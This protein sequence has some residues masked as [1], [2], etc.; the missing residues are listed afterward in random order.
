MRTR[1]RLELA[2]FLIER[3]A[4]EVRAKGVFQRAS[5]MQ[6]GC[7]TYHSHE[8]QFVFTENVLIRPNEGVTSCSLDVWPDGAGKV[9]SMVWKPERPWLP[10]EIVS[11]KPGPWIERLGFGAHS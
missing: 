7:L 10:P 3:V 8:L 1:D 9:F 2:R 5:A 6:P 4:P 11:C